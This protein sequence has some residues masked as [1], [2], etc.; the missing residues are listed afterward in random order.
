MLCLEN[1]YVFLDFV[2]YCYGKNYT[3]GHFDRS[4]LQQPA[5]PLREGIREQP[6]LILPR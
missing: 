2:A 4:L 5:A 1:L 3:E 6:T